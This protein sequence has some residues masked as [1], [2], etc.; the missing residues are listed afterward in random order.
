MARFRRPALG[1]TPLEDRVTPATF[2]YAAG[3]LT[4]TAETGD[5]LLVSLDAENVPGFLHVAS[6]PD[7]FDSTDTQPVRNLVVN[8]G[9]AANYML[10]VGA[11]VSLTDL[12]V[13]GA[14][15]NSTVNLSPDLRLAGN[16]TFTGQAAGGTDTIT[17]FS[18]AQVNGNVTLDLGGG[19]NTV[20]VHGGRIGGNVRV[21]GGAGDDAVNVGLIGAATIGGN[22]SVSLG[23]GFNRLTGAGANSV[24][25]GRNFTY[26]GGAGDDRIDFDTSNT[27]FRV[28]GSVSADLGGMTGA[29]IPP[30]N[31]WHTG[32]LTVG[33]NCSVRGALQVHMDG[34]NFIGGNVT[35]TGVPDAGNTFTMG[36]SPAPGANTMASTVNGSLRYTGGALTDAVALDHLTVRRNVDLRFGAG[37]GSNAY[38]GVSQTAKV[39]VGGALRISSAADVGSFVLDRMRVDGPTTVRTLGGVDQV[40]INDSDLVG[41]VTFDL[42]AGN[43]VVRIDADNAD[44]FGAAL[45]LRT[46]FQS[47]L[48]VFGRDGADA[49][50]LG[51]NA[52]GTGVYVGGPIRLV[53]GA[54][55]DDLTLRT[56]PPPNNNNYLSLSLSEDFETGNDF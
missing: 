30:A 33:R 18:P 9:T 53:G 41:A 40:S 12:T 24:L 31:F 4:V 47:A 17:L 52:S 11:G 14:A 37:P 39:V 3:T 21:T 32:D 55:I 54:G 43:D 36:M 48:T 8:A 2:A 5:A 56:M 25:V 35:V 26:T 10:N 16:F 1:V 49:V 7:V 19:T 44:A 15:T 13:R 23:G 46:R 34:E 45:P 50:S 20:A 28:I 38:V 6:G 29:F 27:Q 51:I 22:L 42:G